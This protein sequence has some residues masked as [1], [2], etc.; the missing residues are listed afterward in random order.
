MIRRTGAMLRFIY[1]Q[2]GE[3]ANRNIEPTPNART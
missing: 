2:E 1:G 3:E